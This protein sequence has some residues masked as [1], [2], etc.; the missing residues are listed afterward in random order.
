[1]KVNNA[2]SFWIGPTTPFVETY[3][4]AYIDPKN[5]FHEKLCDTPPAP[6]EGDDNGHAWQAPLEAV[7]FTGDRYLE[8]TR[9]V[10]DISA[11]GTQHWFNIGCAGSALM[12][13]HLNRHTT[14]SALTGFTATKNER[15]AMFKMFASDLYGDGTV[16]TRK[17]VP[18][19]WQNLNSWEKLTGFEHAFE[20]RW[21][22]KGAQCLD[23]HRLGM[24][25]A[26]EI[27]DYGELIHKKL[28]PCDGDV[29]APS[30]WAN[31][32]L[33]SALPGA[34]PPP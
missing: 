13:L 1:M 27:E 6:Q 25:L 14:A 24:E 18:L 3:E 2:V 8:D 9:E 33:I 15:Q 31:T 19:R 29:A 5:N 17:G 10:T 12:K 16:F 32:L 28:I 34:P 26:Q 11:S 23:T 7:L 22:E 30:F 20:A 21:N 4:L